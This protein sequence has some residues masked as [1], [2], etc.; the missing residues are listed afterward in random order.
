M[1][2]A[3]CSNE[4]LEGDFLCRTHRLAD[5]PKWKQAAMMFK[6][7]PRESSLLRAAYKDLAEND[8]KS[9]L[10][11]L[12]F[13]TGSTLVVGAGLTWTAA[14]WVSWKLWIV[15]LIFALFGVGIG[16]LGMFIQ[17]ERDASGD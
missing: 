4:A 8:F 10:A 3:E 12:L 17:G 7:S 6:R 14:L 15:G 13:L 2:C 1:T 11:R 16:V 9:P 5:L